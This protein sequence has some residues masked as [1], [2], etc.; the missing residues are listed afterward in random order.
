MDRRDYSVYGGAEGGSY[1]NHTNNNNI[2]IGGGG[3]TTTQTY[4]KKHHSDDVSVVQRIF[5]RNMNIYIQLG[6]MK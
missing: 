4:L 5:Y 2:N 6:E 3:D 1:L